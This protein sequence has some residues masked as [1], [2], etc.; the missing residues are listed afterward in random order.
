MSAT[1][2]NSAHRIQCLENAADGWI[3]T[4]FVAN[5]RAKGKQGGTCCHMLAEQLY[6]EV[7][8]PLPFR[9][10]SGSMKWSDVSKKSLI[11][12][13]F[14]EQPR[15]FRT[16]EKADIAAALPG[17]VL[18]FK[19]GGCVHHIGIML[20]APRFVHCMRGIGTRYASLNDPTFKNR[21]EKIWRP[22]P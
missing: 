18:G 6:V 17:D 5:S 16:L 19:I 2:F 3:G 15:L 11:E 8:Y 10:P 7:G 9:V 22:N 20:R 21:L 12:R 14:D 13:F 4:P 1:W